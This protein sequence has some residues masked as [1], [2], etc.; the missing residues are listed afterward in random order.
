MNKSRA[1]LLVVLVIVAAAVLGDQLGMFK[2]SSDAGAI[3]PRDLYAGA[4][5]EANRRE[6]IV[7]TAE[8]I[9]SKRQQADASW[10]TIRDACIEASTRALAQSQFRDRVLSSLR[11]SGVPAPVV[12]ERAPA[13]AFDETDRVQPIALSVRF[14]ADTPEDAYNAIRVLETMPSLWVDVERALLSSNALTGQNT[15]IV[16]E[17]NINAIAIVEGDAS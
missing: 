12:N 6:R 11:A 10:G 3:T 7:A 8:N 2:A 1:I 14:E 13:A 5:A 4:R 17:A 16:V 9:E 15:D